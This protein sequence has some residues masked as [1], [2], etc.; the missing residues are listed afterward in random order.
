LRALTTFGAR[1]GLAVLLG[2]AAGA[3]GSGGGTHVRGS[4]GG[5]STLGTGGTTST[6][7]TTSGTGGGGAAA[8]GAPAT[9]LV[10]AGEVCKSPGYKMVFTL[11][12][13]TQSQSTTKSTSYRMQGGL[14][15]ANGSLP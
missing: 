15:G 2:A 7:T 10:S 5:S 8:H 14:V 1:L 12:Q 9:Q 4:G 13:P 6:S 11:G 3:C